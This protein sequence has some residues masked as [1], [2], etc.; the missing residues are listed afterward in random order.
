MLLQNFYSNL[1]K[2]SFFHHCDTA[3]TLFQ[4]KNNDDGLLVAPKKTLIILKYIFLLP[5]QQYSYKSAA[6]DK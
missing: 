2:W 6:K 4:D 1:K 3:P 5:L